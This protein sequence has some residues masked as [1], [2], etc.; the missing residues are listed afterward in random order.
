VPSCAGRPGDRPRRLKA[1]QRL[2]WPGF[3][4]APPPLTEGL[5]REEHK[6]K[7]P[8]PSRDS[9]VVE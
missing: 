8:P 1:P 7:T 5:Q 3:P 2:M 6:R 4:T 9:G